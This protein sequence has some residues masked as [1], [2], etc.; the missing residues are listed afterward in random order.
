[1]N[2]TICHLSSVHQRYDIRIFHKE[3]NSL[4]KNGYK[5]FL[6]V[7]DG[8]GNE[9]KKDIS[10]ID[11]GG[12]NS[13]LKRIMLSTNKI[14][15]K[16]LEIN[17]DIYHFHDPELLPYGYLLKLNG[18]KV[19]YDSHEDLPRQLLSKPYLNP[20][21]KKMLSYIIEITEDFFSKSFNG[22]VTAT[23]FIAKRFIKLNRNTVNI[24]NYPLL[25]E[26]ILKKNIKNTFVDRNKIC[27]TGGITYIRGIYPLSNAI[28]K[29]NHFLHI[30]GNFENESL[31]KSILEDTDQIIYYGNLDREKLNALWSDCLIGIVNFFPE[32][33][34]INAQPNKIFEYMANGLAIIGSNF[35]LWQEII[36][37][38]SCG[39]CVDPKSS[40]EILDAINYLVNNPKIAEKMGKNGRDLVLNKIN[41][42]IEEKKLIEFYNVILS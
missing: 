36:V 27:Y 41:W 9:E 6:I 15:K 7:A 42:E 35:P 17:A 2:K 10:I 28:K 19:V 14:Y 30:A 3:C 5:V 40:D 21:L 18:K 16:A 32:P 29:S 31:K 37:N 4:A 34:H 33:N 12:K 38:N 24:N 8:K 20:I 26:I 22:I 25:D 39:I 13:R 1:M 23:P 11:V